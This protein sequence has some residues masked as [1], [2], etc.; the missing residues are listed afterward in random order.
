MAFGTGRHESTKLMIR[1]M[2]GLPMEGKS[3]L[4]VGC[5]SGILA[6][7]AWLL[8]AASVCAIDHDPVATEAAKKSFDLNRAGSILLACSGVE[9]IKG[10]FQAVLAN[11]D[12]ST[13]KA[14]ASDVARL[15]ED[16]GWLVVSGI[17][18][19]YAADTPSLFGTANLVKHTRMRDW[20][21]FVFR[22]N[23]A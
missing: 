11:L 14:H 17:E 4:D 16:G 2:S 23:R 8:G 9:A 12:F 20:H 13:F 21:G 6:I 5:G 10:R 3:V 18:R 22:V 19:Q 15:V 7:Y 1:L